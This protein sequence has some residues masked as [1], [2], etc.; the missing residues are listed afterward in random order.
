MALVARNS[1][2]AI[3]AIHCFHLIAPVASCEVKCTGQVLDPG[4]IFSR[5]VESKMAARNRRARIVAF[6]LLLLTILRR[7]K[8]QREQGILVTKQRIPG[9]IPIFSVAR[10]A[11]GGF[12]MIARKFYLIVPIAWIEQSSIWAITI[13]PIVP[14]L[15]FTVSI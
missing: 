9:Y 6:Y 14:Q 3:R 4:L 8:C 10:I 11:W 2:Q 7:N 5:Q 12:H 1:V 13:A 15:S